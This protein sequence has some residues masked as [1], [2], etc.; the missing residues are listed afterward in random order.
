M[1]RHA[2]KQPT[3]P[4]P[5]SSRRRPQILIHTQLRQMSTVRC[6]ASCSL[7]C[8]TCSC[9]KLA[10]RIGRIRVVVCSNRQ[11]LNVLQLVRKNLLC[12]GAASPGFSAA[13]LQILGR[14]N[15]CVQIIK[16]QIIRD[17]VVMNKLKII[18][19]NVANQISHTFKPFAN[20]HR[21]VNINNCLRRCKIRCAFNFL[22]GLCVVVLGSNVGIGKGNVSNADGPVA[23]AEPTPWRRQ[24]R[25]FAPTGPISA[26]AR[27]PDANTRLSPSRL[28]KS[29]TQTHG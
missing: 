8:Q 9:G 10:E 25:C 27:A 19:V 3:A 4:L 12:V 17:Y 20:L 11:S 1:P 26:A 16:S 23:R 6:S 29:T 21:C 2:Q 18:F 13:C 24:T 14:F 28:E 15:E 7:R 22:P 5:L